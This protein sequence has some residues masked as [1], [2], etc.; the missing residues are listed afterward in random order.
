MHPYVIGRGYRMLALED[1]LMRLP[2]GAVFV[3]WK[4]PRRE[5]K[6][7][8]GGMMNMIDATRGR[9]ADHRFAAAAVESFIGAVLQPWAAGG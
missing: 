9:D 1:L 7:A 3:T 6:C 5:L 2:R 4:M 8:Y